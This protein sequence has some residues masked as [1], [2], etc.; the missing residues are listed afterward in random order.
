MPDLTDHSLLHT[1][2]LGGNRYMFEIV[3]KTKLADKP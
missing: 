3:S 1:V 2:Y